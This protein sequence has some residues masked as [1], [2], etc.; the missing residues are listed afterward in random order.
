M[1]L[2]VADAFAASIALRSL[3]ERLPLSDVGERLGRV[4]EQLWSAAV[5]ELGNQIATTEA[6]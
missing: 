5:G 6:L 2:D 4:G 3:R 1:T